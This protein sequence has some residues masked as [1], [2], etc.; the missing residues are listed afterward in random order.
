MPVKNPISDFRCAKR[1]KGIMIRINKTKALKETGK[2]I[3]NL[4]RESSSSEDG[5]PFTVSTDFINGID[6]TKI[7]D[8]IM[9]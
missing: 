7:I 4:S 1:A 9:F 5:Q 3:K 6:S 2:L 8:V